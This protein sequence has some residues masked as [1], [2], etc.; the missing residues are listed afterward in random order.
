ML[1]PVNQL[2][3]DF[4]VLLKGEKIA[5]VEPVGKLKPTGEVK[6]LDGVGVDSA[7]QARA[8]D[9]YSGKLTAEF[10]QDKIVIQKL[11]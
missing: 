6:V 3:G 1:D 10:L 8:R 2:D 9:K 4:D 5:A 7:E 11:A